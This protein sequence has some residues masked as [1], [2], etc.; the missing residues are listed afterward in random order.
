MSFVFR[1]LYIFILYGLIA[2]QENQPEYTLSRGEVGDR[3]VLVEEFSGVRC[4]NCPEGTK[5]LENLRDLYEGKLI[6]V[7]I[8]AGDFAFTYPASKYD[9]TTPE[10]NALLQLL[11]NPIGYPSAVINRVRDNSTQFLQSFS[12]RWGS[13][14]SS[15]LAKEPI[16]SITLDVNFEASERK[17]TAGVR[18]VPNQDISGDLRFNLLIK[19]NNMIDWQSDIEAPQSVDH[20]YNHRNVMRTVLTSVNGD[21]VSSDSR[22]FE[23]LERFY[24]FIVPEESNWWKVQDLWLVAF[25]TGQSGEIMQATEQ[26]L[27]P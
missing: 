7:T 16:L 4:P 19:E 25:V 12:P 23:T 20:A 15:E 6:I 1:I 9:F 17:I 18:V 5:D 24:S 2:C 10:G 26:P 11:G 22:A 27:L 14:I 21:I 8:H 3:V 13:L